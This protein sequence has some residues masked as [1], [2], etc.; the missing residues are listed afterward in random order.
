[1]EANV[2]KLVPHNAWGQEFTIKDLNLKAAVFIPDNMPCKEA[3]EQIKNPVTTSSQ[4]NVT[5]LM[6]WSE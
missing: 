2:P 3:I 4:L 6:N 5:R 1:M